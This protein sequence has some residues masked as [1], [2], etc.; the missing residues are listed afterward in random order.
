LDAIAADIAAVKQVMDSEPCGMTPLC[1][2]VRDATRAIAAEAPR[3]RARGER[4]VLIIASDGAA[5]DG[6]LAAAM[7]PLAALPVWVVVRLCTD[8]RAVVDYWN[9]VDGELELDLEV[10]GAVG[11]APCGRCHAGRRRVR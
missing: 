1:A 3:L 11:D 6:D 4:A 7:R 9:G 10:R 8:D 2:A 5:S